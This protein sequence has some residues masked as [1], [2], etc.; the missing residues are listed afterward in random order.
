MRIISQ[1]HVINYNVIAKNSDLFSK[2]ETELYNKYEEYKYSEN[3]FVVN[4][5]KVNRNLSLKDN[6]IKTNDVLELIIYDVENI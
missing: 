1:D 2:I 6:K 4:G 3:F 5:T